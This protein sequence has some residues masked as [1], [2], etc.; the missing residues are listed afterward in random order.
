MYSSS[1]RF[2]VWMIDA[3]GLSLGIRWGFG[4]CTNVV[5]AVG[6]LANG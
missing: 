1:A 6:G 5:G 3:N 2:I 4:E